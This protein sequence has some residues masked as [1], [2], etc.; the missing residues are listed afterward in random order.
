MII[1]NRDPE[2]LRKCREAGARD[3]LTR[4]IRPRELHEAVQRF[5]GLAGGLVFAESTERP[6]MSAKR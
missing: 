5:I 3:I 1:G 4:P 2:S 6:A